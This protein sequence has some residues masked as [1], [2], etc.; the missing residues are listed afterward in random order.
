MQ[1]GY[2][3]LRFY[4]F[5]SYD[6]FSV[7]CMTDGLFDFRCFS[8]CFVLCMHVWASCCQ[9]VDDSDNVDTESG[10]YSNGDID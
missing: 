5:K 10:K 7:E 4:F 2:V 8:L 1:S 3:E 6:I 9:A